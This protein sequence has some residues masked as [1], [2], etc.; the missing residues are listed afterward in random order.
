MSTHF[1]PLHRFLIPLV[2]C[3]GV[4]FVQAAPASATN[5]TPT[6]DI[7]PQKA[8]G[9]YHVGEKIT[10]DVKVKNDAANSVTAVTYTIRNGGGPSSSREGT[11]TLSQGIGTID[12]TLDAPNT[13]LIEASID[14]PTKEN[15]KEPAKFYG[16]AVAD[17]DK[18]PVSSPTPEDFDAFWKSK[19]DELAAVPINA[20]E[21]KA[22]S[23]DPGVRRSKITMDN[24]RGTHIRGQ[25]ARPVEGEKF[26]AMIVFQWA[27][28]YGMEK[29]WVINPASKGW[30]VLDIN[31]HDLPIDEPKEFYAEQSKNALKYYCEIGNDDRDQSYFLRMY[32]ACYRAVDYLSQRPD[33]NGKVLIVTGISQGGMQSIIAAGINPKVTALM[34]CVPAGCDYTAKLLKRGSGWPNWVE[35]IKWQG[36]AGPKDADKVMEASRY[37][38]AVNFAARV[39]CPALVFLGLRDGCAQPA[40]I[41]AA[42]NQM[43]GAKEVHIMPN[44]DH[45]SGV[46]NYSTRAEAW[47]DLMLKGQPVPP[48]ADK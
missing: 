31:A 16:G 3:L 47:K 25:L 33:W 45:G 4:S 8:D 34:A 12:Y 39:K 35:R 9:I 29:S 10:W 7:T 6:L 13:V 43:Q 2:L 46:N 27:G 17:P 30:L 38:D 37:Y 26:P 22:D 48:P 42:C 41:L 20:V 11:L 14:S 5:S 15:G 28:I 19:L 36:N 21:E 18:I 44:D 40:G 23:Y 24:I 1:R 32:L